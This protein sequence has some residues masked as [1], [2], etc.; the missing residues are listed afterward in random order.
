MAT[1][2]LV[3]DRDFEEQMFIVVEKMDVYYYLKIK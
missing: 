1:A 2:I 3:D